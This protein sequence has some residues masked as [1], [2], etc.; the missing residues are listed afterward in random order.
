MTKSVRALTDKLVDSKQ[1]L[2]GFKINECFVFWNYFS[3]MLQK[4]LN[5][6]TKKDTWTVINRAIEFI[7]YIR[8]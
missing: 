8:N 6:Q 7:T 3:F 2:I 4:C 1:T 5:Q